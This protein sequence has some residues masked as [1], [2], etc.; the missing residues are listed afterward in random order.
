MCA[1]EILKIIKVI[2]IKIVDVVDVVEIIEIHRFFISSRI[3]AA[4]RGHGYSLADVLGKWEAVER[5]GVSGISDVAGLQNLWAS[6]NDLQF[7][8]S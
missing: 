1:R 2:N 8:E 7:S 4:I 6:G 3:T 5:G